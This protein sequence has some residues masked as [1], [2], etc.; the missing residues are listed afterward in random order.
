M[1]FINNAASAGAGYLDTGRVKSVS[2]GGRLL[3]REG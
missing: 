1:N 3:Q 2:G